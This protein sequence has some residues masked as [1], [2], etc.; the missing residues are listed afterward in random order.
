M[1]RQSIFAISPYLRV[2]GAIQ[3]ID[4]YQRA[5]GAIECYRLTEPSGRIGHAELRL[6]T[7][8][9][10]L[11]KE[12]PECGILGPQSLGG[13]G[14]LIHLAVAAVVQFAGGSGQ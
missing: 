4:F 5:F 2:R 1:S 9:L 8:I 3:A 7:S 12:F 11:A 6:E 10:M 14:I 13:T